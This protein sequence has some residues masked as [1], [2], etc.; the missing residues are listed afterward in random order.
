[1]PD[2]PL[3]PAP[4]LLLPATVTALSD[5]W[6]ALFRANEAFVAVDATGS[7]EY[8]RLGM[9]VLKNRLLDCL[10][11]VDELMEETSG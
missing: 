2:K 5:A 9:Q 4:E 7:K 1:M 6:E 11:A 10:R 3:P 8:A